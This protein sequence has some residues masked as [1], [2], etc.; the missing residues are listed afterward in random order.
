MTPPRGTGEDARV[1]AEEV[2][3]AFSNVGVPELVAEGWDLAGRG[4]ENGSGNAG[5]LWYLDFNANGKV[6]KEDLA[7]FLLG[8]C[9]SNRRR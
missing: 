4:A 1:V 3:A 9:R 5:Y 7:L 8:Y 2:N 6:W